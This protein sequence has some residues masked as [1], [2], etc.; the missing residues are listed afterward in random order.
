MVLAGLTGCNVA[1]TERDVRGVEGDTVTEPLQAAPLPATAT[2]GGGVRVPRVFISYAHDCDTHRET[3]RDLWIFLRAHGVNARI[4]RVAAEQRTDWTLWM[5]R[6]VA[7]ADRIL[8]VASPAYRQRAGHE[9]DLGGGAGVQY[10][11]RLI[12]NLF[13]QDQSALRRFLPVVLPGGSPDDLPAFLTPA[14]ATVYR[15]SAFTVDGAET[16]LRVLHD[17]PGEVEPPLGPVPDLPTRGHTFS[18][19]ATVSLVERCFVGVTVERFSTR[20]T[21]QQVLIQ[22]EL[23]R[24]LSE[25]AE[26][27]GLPRARWERQPSG[28]GGVAVLP[29]NI[30]L[31]ALVGTFTVELDR[32]LVEHNK[33]HDLG[34]HIRLRVAMHTDLV[35]PGAFGYGGPALV[36]LNRLLDSDLLRQVL[37]NAS[38]ESL[39]QLLSEPL[40]RRAVL[41]E[42]GGLRPRQFGKVRVTVPGEGFRQYAYLRLSHGRPLARVPA[43]TG[44]LLTSLVQNTPVPRAE[45]LAPTLEPDSEEEPL[46][47]GVRGLVDGVREA[48]ADGAVGQADRLTTLALLEQA[49]REGCLRRADAEKI[50]D[51]LLAELDDGWASASGGWWGFRAQRARL[52]ALVLSGRRPVTGHLPGARLADRARRRRAALC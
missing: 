26:A 30:D 2:T 23:D 34:A 43:S 3:V 47:S 13:Y 18:A 29:A 36:L 49:G 21:R 20:V 37:Q 1:A 10:E 25:A 14:V 31:V 12:R 44:S 28:G 24:M 15:V 8:V 6:Q 9:A 38:D 16:L 35:T 7:E 17:R 51:G 46:A 19:A 33:D 11:A 45:A 42:L 52:A 22:K 48:L 5:E 50:P 40:Y 39:V 4:D 27:A 32:R 41:P